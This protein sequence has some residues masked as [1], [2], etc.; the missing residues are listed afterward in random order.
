MSQTD[1]IAGLTVS[2]PATES[3][4]APPSRRRVSSTSSVAARIPP[5]AA[6]SASP[7]PSLRQVDGAH[8]QEEHQQRQHEAEVAE[9]R[10]EGLESVELVGLHHDELAGVLERRAVEERR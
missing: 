9:R 3:T 4:T 1:W 8:V 10:D 7:A 5:P 2:E 6:I